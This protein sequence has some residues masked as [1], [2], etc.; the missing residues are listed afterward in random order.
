[1]FSGILV[2]FPS[3]CDLSSHEAGF[4]ACLI[5]RLWIMKSYI[6][7]LGSLRECS[8]IERLENRPDFCKMLNL[9]I[10]KDIRDYVNQTAASAPMPRGRA[11]AAPQPARVV[12]AGCAPC[13]SWKQDCPCDI[14][15]LHMMDSKP[16]GA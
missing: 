3:D 1:M 15:T 9:K 10:I 2:K 12:L 14:E 16:N 7:K 4:Y 11:P 8:D 13:V 5:S 6:G